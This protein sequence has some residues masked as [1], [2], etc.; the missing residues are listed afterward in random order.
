MTKTRKLKWEKQL[1]GRFKR[2]INTIPHE[3]TWTWLRKGNLKRETKYLL[4]TAQ[5]N[6]IRSNHIKA[7]IDKTRQNSKCR[8]CGDRVETT[9]HIISECSK[10]AQMEYKVRHDWVGKVIQWEMCKKLKFDHTNKWYIHNTVPVLE[11]NKHLSP[12]FE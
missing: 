1:Y 6:A 2:L 9:N 4:I 7:I 10:L 3:K 8:L 11:N 12:E 5:D